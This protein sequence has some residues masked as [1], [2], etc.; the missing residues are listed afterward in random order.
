MGSN[1]IERSPILLT[2]FSEKIKSISC[3]ISHSLFLTISK[4]IYSVGCN[5][6]GQ[7]GIGSRKPSNIPI[8]NIHLEKINI[9]KIQA[10]NFSIALSEKG[11]LYYWGTSFFGEELIPKRLD[12]DDII[13]DVNIGHNFAIITIDDGKHFGWGMNQ[14]G[15]LGLG[16]YENKDFL[17]NIS[18][19]NNRT[20]KEINCGKNFV[21]ALGNTI[22]NQSEENNKNFIS[23]KQNIEK[24]SEYFSNRNDQFFKKNG[25]PKKK[26]NFKSYNINKNEIGFDSIDYEDKNN[27]VSNKSMTPSIKHLTTDEIK[28]RQKSS[29][30]ISPKKNNEFENYR[31]NSKN[32]LTTFRDIKNK[33]HDLISSQRDL[34]KK[35][36]EKDNYKSKENFEEIT[37]KE[38][39]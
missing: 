20:I 18:A 4:N 24:Y 14:N 21:M 6:E 7:L 3:G 10:S 1:K 31:E 26:R 8:R 28:L 9:K 17:A 30:H 25:S 5:K 35:K 29:F 13:S 34:L 16:D 39:F 27:K 11:D 36:N 19:L 22:Q 15:E 37:Q 12:Y 32:Y 38:G 23:M 33:E 2:S